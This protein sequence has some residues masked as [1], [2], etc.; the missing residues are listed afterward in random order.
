MWNDS[1]LKNPDYRSTASELVMETRLMLSCYMRLMNECRRRWRRTDQAVS[2]LSQRC[3]E[4]LQE[5]AIHL[6]NDALGS[7][8]GGYERGLAFLL[9][10]DTRKRYKEDQVDVSDYIN[11]R[12]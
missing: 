4:M 2:Y 7:W 9:K 3:Q 1:D 12:A 5:M 6:P 10:L 11:M 8:R